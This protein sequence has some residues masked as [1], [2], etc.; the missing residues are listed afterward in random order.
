MTTTA[1]SPRL[2]PPSRSRSTRACRVIAPPPRRRPPAPPPGDTCRSRTSARTRS[3]SRSPG[4]PKPPPPPVI[5]RTTS[6][7]LSVHAAA[8]EQPPLVVAAGVDR[9]RPAA[10]RR[11]R[12][13]GPRPG[14][15][16][17]SN[18]SDS[19]ALVAADLVLA[20]DA[21]AAAP[22]AGAAGVG[23][24][25]VVGHAHR[26]LRLQHLDRQ[27]LQRAVDVVD[28]PA[29]AVGAVPRAPAADGRLEVEPGLAVARVDARQRDDHRVAVAGAGRLLGQHVRERLDHQ[30]DQQAE[31]REVPLAGRGLLGGE[32]RARAH[33]APQSG[34]KAPPSGGLSGLISSL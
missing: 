2:R 9:R 5:V 18:Q 33:R 10:S 1:S 7:R 28:Q 19:V 6:P 20:D 23:A 15:T 24:E 26:V 11:G 27:V 25:A 34:R 3:G 17:R 13:T 4:A 14:V 8:L 22:P 21:V 29:L 30:V 12:R 16:E 32:H 31:R